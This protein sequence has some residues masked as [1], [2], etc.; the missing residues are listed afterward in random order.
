MYIR[1]ITHDKFFAFLIS[2]QAQNE[3]IK[4][5]PKEEI[6]DFDDDFDDEALMELDE[7]NVNDFIWEYNLQIICLLII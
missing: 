1:E 2:D 4:P 5:K 3:D 6:E 7:S